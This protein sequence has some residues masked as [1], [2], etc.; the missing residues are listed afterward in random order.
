[1]VKSLRFRPAKC[2]RFLSVAVTKHPDQKQLEE[3]R[4]Y[5]ALTTL[6]LSITEGSQGRNSSRN[7]EVG[8]IEECS[9]SGFLS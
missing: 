2:S 9:L 6:S 7:Q 3:K 4:I 5:L 8:T 1:M